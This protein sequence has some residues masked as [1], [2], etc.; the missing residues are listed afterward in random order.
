MLGQTNQTQ[1]GLLVKIGQI[2]DIYWDVLL[3]VSDF[4]NPPFHYLFDSF[5]DIVMEGKKS[6]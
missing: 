2:T 5:F 4:Q 6:L 3:L 1:Y